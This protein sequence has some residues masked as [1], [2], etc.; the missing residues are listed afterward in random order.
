[1]HQDCIYLLMSDV[2]CIHICDDNYLHRYKDHH[3]GSWHFQVLQVNWKLR[4]QV[5]LLGSS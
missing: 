3:L 2:H 4:S 5:S 1:M